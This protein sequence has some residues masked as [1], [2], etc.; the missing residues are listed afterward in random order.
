MFINSEI[1][2]KKVLVHYPDR[3]DTILVRADSGFYSNNFLQ[4]LENY[5]NVSFVGKAKVKYCKLDLIPDEAFNYYHE[6]LRQYA[7]MRREIDDKMERSY[8]LVRRCNDNE[9]YLFEEFSFGFETI[10]SNEFGV[11]QCGN[12]IAAVSCAIIAI[13]REVALRREFRKYRMK[14]LRYYFLNVVAYKTTHSRRK[15]IKIL[16][17]PIG[18]WRYDQVIK[19]IYALS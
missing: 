15:T 12:W 7:K 13:F 8:Y 2:L 16:S 17:P 19:R 10:V 5:D 14:L 11:T 9:I 3:V 1:K 4:A 18:R 6:S